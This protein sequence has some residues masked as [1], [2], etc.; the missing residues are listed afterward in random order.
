QSSSTTTNVTIQWTPREELDHLQE[1]ASFSGTPFAWSNS[2]EYV[3]RFADLDLGAEVPFSST[4]KFFR[5][6]SPSLHIVN[7][8]RGQSADF[9][10]NVV[11]SV[12]ATGTPPIRYL[13]TLNGSVLPGQTN[14]T[15][16]VSL[17]S[18]A[19]FGAYQASVFNNQDSLL[20]RAAVLRLIGNETVLSDSFN[21]R[22]LFTSN[23]VSI[24]GTTFSAT[25][26][27]AEP[28]HAG[29]P[30]GRSV[31]LTWRS[32]VSGIV[33]FDTIGSGFDTLLAAY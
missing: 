25:G 9:L 33:T 18:Y 11:L 19:N 29:V 10:D 26:E 13:W 31:W 1:L 5:V 32:P 30:G 7:Q 15:L 21:G 2:A 6:A 8:P 22:Q 4:S 17:N 3:G 27:A 16:G 24:H 23:S 12:T 14:S 20:S 28:L